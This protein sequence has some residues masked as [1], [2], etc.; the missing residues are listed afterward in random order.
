V[1]TA[2]GTDA[3]SPAPSVNGS[4]RWI[5]RTIRPVTRR[6]IARRLNATLRPDVL[7]GAGRTR[8]RDR[9]GLAKHL[10]ARRLHVFQ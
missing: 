6:R 9:T 1:A 3:A 4:T 7:P 5:E 10:V 2:T 8:S